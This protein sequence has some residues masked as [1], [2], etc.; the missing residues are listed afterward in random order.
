MR[1]FTLIELL[2][3]I[4]IIAILA[5]MLL[6]ALGKA[7]NK[8]RAVSC[9]SEMRQGVLFQTLYMDDYGYYLT[10]SGQPDGGTW[11]Y[12]LYKLKYMSLDVAKCPSFGR[13]STVDNDRV[14]K[15]CFGMYMGPNLDESWEY[16]IKP[17][18]GDYARNVVVDGKTWRVLIPQAMRMTSTLY[19]MSETINGIDAADRWQS[20]FF[21]VSRVASGKEGFLH[22]R[23]DGRINSGMADGSVRSETPAQMA[24]VIAAS[25]RFADAGWNL[26]KIVNP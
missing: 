10:T 5:S 2:V 6:P 14:W 25:V 24:A 23:H 9:V 13:H 8:A 16:S 1:R 4:A 26:Q 18:Y 20:P 15:N 3:V 17:K 19:I 12:Y 22:Q 11:R 7:R 21:C